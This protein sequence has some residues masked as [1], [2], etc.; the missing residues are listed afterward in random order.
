MVRKCS[1]ARLT[2][3]GA[4]RWKGRIESNIRLRE[5]VVVGCTSGAAG[6]DISDFLRG[7]G[8]GTEFNVEVSEN[9]FLV[10][11][12]PDGTIRRCGVKIH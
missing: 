1:P 3:V 6:S 12:K 5:L 8:A 11:A 2:A 9:Q 7:P 4:R 10:T